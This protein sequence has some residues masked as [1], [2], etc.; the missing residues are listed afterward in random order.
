MADIKLR[1]GI[2]QPAERVYE[3]FTT[4]PGI[5]GFWTTTVEGEPGG[6]GSLQFFFGQPDPAATV[7]VAQA[8]PSKLVEWRC[9]QGPD[10][11][12]GTSIRFELDERDGE[13]VVLFTHGDWREASEFMRHCGTKWAYFLIGLKSWLEGAP[14]V[15]FP[16]DLAIS[17]WG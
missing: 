14:S 2:N 11:W 4:I 12:V 5:Q 8:S 15:A 10:E 13:T 6:G 16:G 17:S 7:E 1:V 9:V 3:S